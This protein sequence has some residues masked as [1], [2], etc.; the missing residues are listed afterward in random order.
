MYEETTYLCLDKHRFVL[1][2]M[3]NYGKNIIETR[4]QPISSSTC[5]DSHQ[6][7]RQ[8]ADNA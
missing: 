6:V 4:K 5:Y 1:L 7:L 2:T 3:Q 8:N